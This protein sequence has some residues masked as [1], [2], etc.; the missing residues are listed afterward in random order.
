MRR[1]V[2]VLRR[3]L[4]GSALVTLVTFAPLVACDGLKRADESADAGGDGGDSDGAVVVDDG[5]ALDAKIEGSLKD[6]GEPPVDFECSGADSWV[7]AAKA[8]PE[9]APRQVKI[10]ESGSAY[11]A[12][13]VSI[14][15]TPAGRVGIVFNSELNPDEGELHFWHFKPTTPTYP[16]PVLVKRAP[17]GIGFHEGYLSKITAS[18]PDTLALLTFDTDDVVGDVHYR[19]LVAGALPLT[20]EVAFTAVKKPTEIAVASDPAGN[21][22]ASARIANGTNTARISTKKKTATGAFT[23]LTPLD[24]A[25]ALM[26]KEAPGIGSASIF[27]DP[28]NQP[29]LVYHYNDGPQHSTPRYHVLAGS[30]WSARKTVDNGVPDGISGYSARV[31]AFG[32]KKYAAYFFRKAGQGGFPTADLRLATWESLGDMP[33]I[34]VIEQ[35]VVSTQPLSPAYSLAMAIDKFGL[36]HLVTITGSSA[37]LGTL[38]YRRQTRVAGGGTKWVTDIVDPDV[39][40][41]FSPAYVDIVVDEN[42]RPHIA[43]LSAKDGKVKYATRFDR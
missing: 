25:S 4:L 40:A 29:H 18:A 13:G 2:A 16:A 27:I 33:T 5:G 1:I 30:M 12:T 35:G 42:A 36:L 19:K 10:I 23:D 24:L 38:E 41:E 31:V 14:A 21:V 8:R 17:F 37:T 20:D 34:E 22:Y 7:K 3:V 32:T 9:C 39:L 15:R 6:V 11:D 28:G 26:P 43:Y